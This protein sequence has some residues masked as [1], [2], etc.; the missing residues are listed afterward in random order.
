MEKNIGKTDKTIRAIAALIFIVLAYI[1]SP[2][3][4]LIPA[5]I[6]FTILTGFCLPYKLLGISTVKKEK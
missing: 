3:L 2:W 5:L 4:Y 6:I 1:S